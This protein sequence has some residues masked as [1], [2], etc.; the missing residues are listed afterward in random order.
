VDTA[1]PPQVLREKV[2]RLTGGRL[3]C[4]L[5]LDREL[6]GESLARFY[7]VANDGNPSP[8]DFHVEGRV[9]SYECSADD[10]A[11]WR[12]AAEIFLVK[13][14]RESPASRPATDD[15]RAKFGLRPLHR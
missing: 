8:T 13:S 9:V 10:E 12:L 6:R 11:R 15:T 1:H 4:V 3:A 14:H 2:S 7:S 5:I